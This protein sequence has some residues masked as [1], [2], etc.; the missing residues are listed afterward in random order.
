MSAINTAVAPFQ[1]E[2]VV[3]I[4][5]VLKLTIESELTAI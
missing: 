5:S 4:Y 2:V 1:N 3:I